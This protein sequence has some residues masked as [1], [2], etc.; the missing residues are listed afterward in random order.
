MEEGSKK[1]VGYYGSGAAVAVPV[2]KGEENAGA[3]EKPVE[4][5]AKSDGEEVIFGLSSVSDL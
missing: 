2:D 3:E 4:E 5:E 1:L